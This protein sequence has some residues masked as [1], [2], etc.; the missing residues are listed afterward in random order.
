MGP[1]LHVS[2]IIQLYLC[3]VNYLNLSLNYSE[4]FGLHWVNYTHP[5]KPR[6][7]KKSAAVLK[8]IFS[9]NGF[10]SSSSSTIIV[11][12]VITYA[13]AFVSVMYGRLF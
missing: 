9:D 7:P 12:T 2:K 10:P 5:D 11:L 13:F 6:I 4:R 1:R 8:Q 3:R